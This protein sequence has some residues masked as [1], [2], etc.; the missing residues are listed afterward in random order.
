[1][2]GQSD[3]LQNVSL[4]RT[5]NENYEAEDTLKEYAEIHLESKN[6][7]FIGN[8][9]SILLFLRTSSL[10][11]TYIIPCIMPQIIL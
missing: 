4:K 2:K 5:V 9:S 8:T 1:M 10:F 11:A 7:R 6:E 3:H